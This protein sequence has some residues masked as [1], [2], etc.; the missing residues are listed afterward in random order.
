MKIKNWFNFNERL[1]DSSC[2]E[3]QGTGIS[4]DGK[5]TPC[6]FCQGSRIEPKS[7]KERIDARRRF[8][9]SMGYPENK[10]IDLNDPYFQ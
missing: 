7:G 6:E 4:D 9:K 3:C 8:N 1:D 5:K 10:D 2:I